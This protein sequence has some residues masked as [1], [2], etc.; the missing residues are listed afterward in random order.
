MS[1]IQL[2]IYKRNH[3][4]NNEETFLDFKAIAIVEQVLKW[5]NSRPMP[6]YIIPL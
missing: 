2:K 5:I 1:P 3:Q 4:R 6:V